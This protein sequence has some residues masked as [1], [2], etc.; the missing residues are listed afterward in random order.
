MPFGHAFYDVSISFAS[1][2]PSPHEEPLQTEPLSEVVISIEEHDEHYD[3]DLESIASHTAMIPSNNSQRPISMPSGDVILPSVLSRIQN[4]N[5]TKR[6]PKTSSSESHSS[7]LD[8]TKHIYKK[9]KDYVKG[10]KVC[11]SHDYKYHELS[12]DKQQLIRLI[13]IDLGFCMAT[14][15]IAAHQIE[16]NLHAISKHFGLV[17]N[18]FILPTGLW[19][20][21]NSVLGSYTEDNPQNLSQY[22]RVFS[23]SWNLD[24]LVQVDQLASDISR[25]RYVDLKH[26]RNRIKDIVAAPTAFSHFLFTLL[27]NAVFA[28]MFCVLLNGNYAEVIAAL[29]G[30]LAVGVIQVIKP[31]SKH[32]T[33]ISNGLSAAIGGIIAVLVRYVAGVTTGVT[34]DVV[35]VA[36]MSVAVLLPG[37]GITAAIADLNS[38]NPASGS[39]RTMIVIA[40]VIEI[41]FGIIIANQIDTFFLQSFLQQPSATRA[42]LP[43]WMKFLA[44]PLLTLVLILWQRVPKSISAYVFLFIDCCV[45]YFGAVYIRQYTGVEFGGMI[46]AFAVG[47][48]ANIFSFITEMPAAVLTSGCIVFLAPSY[49]ATQGLQ[50]LLLQDP[51][52]A[53]NFL[54]NGLIMSISVVVG[55]SLSDMV[56]VR[57]KH[58]L[59]L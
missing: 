48:I 24:K 21:F 46:S 35:L 20:N 51:T 2:S 40:R 54:F 30:G 43:I 8:R 38:G 3:H 1:L 13:I 59:V 26:I 14:Y 4:Q 53:V 42:V 32:L 49:I 34:V 17:G 18:Y 57:R 29:F 44:L 52:S 11:V 22:I 41:G 50:Q 31:R 5:L 28:P 10:D 23:T 37:L 27:L 58:H 16:H 36:V 33:K 7:I 25:G 15:G 47:L 12:P 45:A 39:V 56:S 55:L 19:F 9:A 6:S